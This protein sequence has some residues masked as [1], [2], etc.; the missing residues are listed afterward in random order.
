M[1]HNVSNTFW[2]LEELWRQ[3][4]MLGQLE[5]CTFILRLIGELL[6]GRELCNSLGNWRFQGN[7][8]WFMA[9]SHNLQ[10]PV[11]T[12]MPKNY[13]EIIVKSDSN[14]NHPQVPHMFTTTYHFMIHFRRFSNF[15]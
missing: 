3:L 8:W 1:E 13:H 4:Q 15:P 2:Q 14:Q 9:C 11:K 12:S 10:I 7:N 5:E 6:A